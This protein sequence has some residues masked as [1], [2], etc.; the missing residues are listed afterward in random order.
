MQ[1]KN[2]KKLLHH[3][4]WII[5]IIVMAAGIL[6]SGWFAGLA[7][8]GCA[9]VLG[10]VYTLFHFGCWLY[11]KKKLQQMCS[12][13][14]RVLHGS[15]SMPMTEYAEGEL[16][17]LQTEIHK[18]TIRLNAQTQALKADKRYLSDA[19]ADIS[20]QLKTPLTSMNLLL[21]FLAE[22]NI[23]E[24]R[25]RMLTAK[26]ND[27]LQHVEWLIATLLKMSKLDADA[28][29]FKREP[30]LVSQLIRRSHQEIA[31]AMD[32][33]AQQFVCDVSETVLF[34]GDLAW[35]VEAVENIIK[36]CMEH[37]HSGGTI[38]VEALQNTLF[39][40]IKIMDDGN[41][42]AKEDLP[43]VFERFYQGR[44]AKGVLNGTISDSGGIGI[45]LAFAAM[46]IQ[47][48]NGTITVNN[49]LSGGTE[50]TIKFYKDVI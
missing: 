24:T 1:F 7:A 41:G 26:L 6:L 9:A 49:R 11:Q 32:L 5:D 37:T 14:D 22:E 36:N 27:S 38:T 31:V 12:D 15:Y 47:R 16:S 30:V 4:R 35:S 20:H 10:A 33:K 44:G 48:Q 8:A 2:F 19:L 28:V 3:R 46:I 17:I 42:I 25:R 40:Q 34:E 18:M 43:H 13:I 23:G 45:G 39:T 29:Y 21:E 50:F